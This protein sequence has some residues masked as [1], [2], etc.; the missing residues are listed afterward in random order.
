MYETTLCRTFSASGTK[1][2]KSDEYCIG[3]KQDVNSYI[4]ISVHQWTPHTQNVRKL[5]ITTD[6][7]NVTYKT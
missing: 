7:S 4:Y 5:K 3:Y 6:D 2:S 1:R